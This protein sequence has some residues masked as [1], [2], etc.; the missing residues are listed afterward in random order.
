[1]S[2]GRTRLYNLISLFFLLMAVLVAVL[3]VMVMLRPV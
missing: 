3:V 2:N 1:M